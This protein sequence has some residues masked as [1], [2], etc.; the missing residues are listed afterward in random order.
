MATNTTYNTLLQ[1]M[2]N[3]LERGASPV[4]DQ[5]VFVQ[6]PRLINA[7]ERKIMQ[8]LKLLGSLE[9]LVDPVGFTAGNSVITKPDRWRQTV[10]IWYGAAS[11]NNQ[12]TPLF[13]RDYE[14]CRN[15]WPDDTKTAPPKFYADYGYNNW[16]I[17]PTPDATYPVEV[18]AYLQPQLLDA[19]NQT[20]FFTN[21]TPNLLLYSSLLEAAPFL[22]DDP[23]V[24]TWEHYRD[25]ELQTL[26]GQELQ[27]IL[28][29][30]AK[31]DRP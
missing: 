26:D 13:F 18:N 6:L 14:Y 25:F 23:R 19:S 31:R 28:D 5:S 3:Y 16:L 8:T 29:R 12:R 17:S 21:Y 30:S 2:T 1:D 11:S 4:T 27:R 15:Y 7:A 9:V 10:S 22:K 24:Q 20:N